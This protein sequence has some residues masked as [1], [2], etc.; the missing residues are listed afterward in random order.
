MLNVGS[1]NAD[2]FTS[3]QH[4]LAVERLGLNLVVVSETHANPATLAPMCGQMRIDWG[5]AP[6]TFAGLALVYRPSCRTA[7]QQLQFDQGS[8][9]K[10]QW[11]QGRVAGWLVHVRAYTTPL[12]LY[13]I[14]GDASS[15]HDRGKRRI[16]EKTIEA[17]AQDAVGRGLPAIMCGD[18]NL[19]YDDSHVFSKIE[20]SGWT[21][22]AWFS[23]HGV[24]FT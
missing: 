23:E 4:R 1:I 3:Q 5:A 21:N 20:A 11:S 19:E 6:N 12:L 13:G 17:A 15:R 9:L 16:T 7:V 8:A 10:E 18:W 2:G 14:Y 22:A 24:K